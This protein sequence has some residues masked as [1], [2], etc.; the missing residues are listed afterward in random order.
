MNIYKEQNCVGLE[1]N[2]DFKKFFQILES[3]YYEK[4]INLVL[5]EKGLSKNKIYKLAKNKQEEDFFDEFSI[6]CCQIYFIEKLEQEI[7]SNKDVVLTEKQK[8]AFKNRLASLKKSLIKRK[9]FLQQ[10]ETE[11]SL[12][13]KLEQKSSSR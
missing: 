10:V 8:T 1:S 13:K 7:K 5:K 4:C 6:N 9:D 3:S 12:I 11:F 2:K